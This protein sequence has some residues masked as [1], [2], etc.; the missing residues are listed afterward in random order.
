M[1]LASLGRPLRIPRVLVVNMEKLIQSPRHIADC[2]LSQIGTCSIR[3]CVLWAKPDLHIDFAI[4]FVAKRVRG[5]IGRLLQKL[6]FIAQPRLRRTLHC[7]D[8]V[9]GRQVPA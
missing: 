1:R 9:P 5:N 3:A 8:L 2:K 4:K 7:I 6:G